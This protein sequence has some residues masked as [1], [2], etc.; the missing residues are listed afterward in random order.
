MAKWIIKL[1]IRILGAC[2][3]IPF[4]IALGTFGLVLKLLGFATNKDPISDSSNKVAQKIWDET[5]NS[6]Q[7]K[8]RN[9]FKAIVLWFVM[10]LLLT[11]GLLYLGF[12]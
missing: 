12:Q 8:G 4:T 3:T 6:V 9:V 1:F 10:F 11:F 5:E 7:G 2:I